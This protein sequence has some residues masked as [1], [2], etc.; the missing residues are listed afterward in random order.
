MT[1]TPHPLTAFPVII[2]VGISGA[3]KSTALHVF[4]DLRFVTADG[5]PP[6]VLPEMASLLHGH[7]GDIIRGIALGV[8]LPHDGFSRALLQA[9]KRMELDGTRPQLLFLS[10][11]PEVILR[12]YATTRR[13]HPLEREGVGLEKAMEEEVQRLEQVRAAADLV[14][15]TSSCSIH[16]LR[17]MIQHRWQS[18]E[19]RIR[20]L[21]VNLIS[22]GFKYGV[23]G[24][25]DL[26]FD[27]RFLPNPFFVETLRTQS[28]LDE[29]VADYVFAD[30][31]AATFKQKFLDF[32]S[33]LLPYYDN[34]GRYRLTIAIGCTGGRHRSVA[35]TEALART[36]AQQD[37]AVSI[38]H[39]HIGRG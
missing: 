19:G 16:D 35:M 6:A 24:D 20:A 5:L 15:D 28:G 10:A 34:E 12:R 33:F 38:E 9:M 21:K 7:P 2:V 26:V 39:R 14:I 4:E 29:C 1:D 37:Y 27:M 31:Q 23:P 30:P 32:I 22:F 8:A 18:G 25:A 11:S 13:P 36:L 17:R 3:G